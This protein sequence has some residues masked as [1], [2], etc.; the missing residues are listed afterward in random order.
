M[1]GPSTVLLTGAAGF[2]GFHVARRLLEAGYTVVGLD[3]FNDFYAPALKRRNAADL[4]ALGGDRF[5]MVEGDL[6]DPAALAAF[7]PAENRPFDLVHLA[8]MAGVRPSFERPLLYQEVNVTG[9]FLLLEATRRRALG[10]LVFGSSSSVYGASSRLP[11][12]EDDPVADPLS[13]YAVTKL[14]GE[15]IAHAYHACH[16]IPATCLRF[17]T[18]FGPRQRPEM[19]I[20]KFARDILAG[21]A[22]PFLGDGS[23]TRDY[24]Y[25][26]D[27]VDGV[28]AALASGSGY[29]VFNLGGGHRITLREMVDRL[30]AALGRAPRLQYAP[31][32]PGDMTHT[33]ADISWAEQAL[34]YRPS[35]SFE[36]G[37]ERF[38][39]WLLAGA[40]VPT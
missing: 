6:R 34:G 12:R 16:G 2:I 7:L 23:S 40:D 29:R 33:L 8:A 28:V 14:I 13:P 35:C 27:I 36:A 37:L 26:D 22:I 25:V 1:A 10:H 20:H 21:R 4:A 24:T 9:T 39:A 15:R 11:F 5:R 31:P 3:N 18:V 30:A 38:A 32:H 19:A 17:F